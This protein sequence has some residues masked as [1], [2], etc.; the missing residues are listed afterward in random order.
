MFILI[1]QILK[2]NFFEFSEHKKFSPLNDLNK[3]VINY[4]I[5][6]HVESYNFGVYQVNT[7][8]NLKN[9]KE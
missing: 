5:I 7:R 2:S 9:S 3:K 1:S 4:K 8:G 6:D